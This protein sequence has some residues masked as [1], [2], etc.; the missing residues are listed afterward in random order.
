MKTTNI[1]RVVVVNINY[2]EMYHLPMFYSSREN[3]VAAIEHLMEQE[4]LRCYTKENWDRHPWQTVETV[5]G[6]RCCE[7][8]KTA[9]MESEKEDKF[10]YRD[11]RW[12]GFVTYEMN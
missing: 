4:S 11:E 2:R 3:A 6:S 5:D 8:V 9:V 12:Y 7:F 1:Y 10:S